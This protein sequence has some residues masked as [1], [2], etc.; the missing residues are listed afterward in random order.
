[1]ITL[2]TITTLV[3][4]LG[5]PI[6]CCCVMFYQNGKLQETLSELSNTLVS[7][8]ER[9]NDIEQSVKRGDINES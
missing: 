9:L 2:D 6:A 7:M 1:M 5:F 8:N 3:G 4:S